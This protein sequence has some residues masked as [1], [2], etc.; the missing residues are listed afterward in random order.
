[1]PAGALGSVY[2]IVQ[3]ADG[4][5]WIGADAGL[6]R[7]DGS[8]FTAWSRFG[9]LHV[10]GA[11]ARSLWVARDASVWVGFS[12]REGVGRIKD[13]KLTRYRDGLSG[14][15]AVTDLIEDA[16]GVMWAVGDRAL[17]K[18]EG[19]EWRK[20]PLP[21]KTIEGQV[22]HP[23]VAS[24]GQMWVATRWGVFRREGDT[25]RFIQVTEDL[26]WGLGEDAAGHIW[27]TDIATGFRQLGGPQ[28]SHP[29]QG[30]G[31][32]LI[33]DRNNHS[34]SRRSAPVCGV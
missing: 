21:W 26:I 33:H 23:Y 11:S 8:R 17:F 28:P 15:D 10:P 20:I 6:F 29:L 7:F 18:L 4:Y 22:Y 2:G 16:R 32:R 12:Q 13:G 31:Y 3:D 30:G 34:G 9:D 5:L 1:M 14:I 24:N 19:G 27:A 25:D